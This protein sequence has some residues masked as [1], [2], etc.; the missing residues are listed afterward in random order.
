MHHNTVHLL[1]SKS[2]II[3][4]NVKPEL[5]FSGDRLWRC[6]AFFDMK[7]TQMCWIIYIDR[8]SRY[9]QLHQSAWR[10][11]RGYYYTGHSHIVNIASKNTFWKNKRPMGHI[12][13]LSNTCSYENTFRILI[14]I[15]FP[16]APPDSQEPWF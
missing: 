15:S 14:Y 8:R 11:Q 12:A 7:F 2:L 6:Y 9:C 1:Q 10:V 16:F 3:Q 5:H 13:H 4:W